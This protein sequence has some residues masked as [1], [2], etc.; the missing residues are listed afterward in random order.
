MKNGKLR[1]ELNYVTDVSGKIIWEAHVQEVDSVMSM[2]AKKPTIDYSMDK[3]KLIPKVP[4]KMEIS[5]ENLL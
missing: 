4:F 5:R 1:K 3:E 2:A